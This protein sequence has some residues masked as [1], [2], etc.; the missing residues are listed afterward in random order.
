MRGSIVLLTVGGSLAQTSVVPAFSLLGVVP[1]VPLVV[2]VLIALRRGPEAGCL[3][4]F[5]AGLLQDAAG[6]GLVGVQALTKALAGFTVGLL[7]GRLRVDNPLVQ[8]PALVVLTVAEG[9]GRLGLLRLFHFTPPAGELL[10]HVIVPQALY[11]GALG[12]ACLLALA[13]AQALREAP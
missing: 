12:A 7:G 4:G 2:T 5:G 6:A 3:V 13:A 9:L 8:V 10:L 11:N 1:D